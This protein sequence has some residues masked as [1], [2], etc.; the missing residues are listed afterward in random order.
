M[1]D[2]KPGDWYVSTCPDTGRVFVVCYGEDDNVAEVFEHLG[3][4]A[5]ENAEKIAKGL[6]M[7]EA[8]TQ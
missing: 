6:N 2:K 3:L 1:T 8:V 4:S 5:T 7:L